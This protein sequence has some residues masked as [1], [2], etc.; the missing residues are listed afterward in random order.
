MVVLGIFSYLF[1]RRW[2]LHRYTEELWTDGCLG[3]ALAR[4]RGLTGRRLLSIPAPI[5][6]MHS[7]FVQVIQKRC[8]K[9]LGNDCR[10]RCL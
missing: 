10:W 2:A 7:K 5:L 8:T 3:G 4:L 9:V 6:C 1:K